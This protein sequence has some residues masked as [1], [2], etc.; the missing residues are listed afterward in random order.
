MYGDLCDKEHGDGIYI[1]DTISLMIPEL[2]T[3]V[4]NR[5]GSYSVF[6]FHYIP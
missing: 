4:N 1:F 6:I 5:S 3:H 2:S